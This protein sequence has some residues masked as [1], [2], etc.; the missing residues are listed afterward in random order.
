M[1]KNVWIINRSTG[2]C[3][4]NRAFA[5]SDVDEN[6][7][8]GLISAIFSFAKEIGADSI[9]SLDMGHTQVV[10]LASEYII[11]AL[12][13]FKETSDDFVKIILDKIHDE[14]DRN[15][16]KLM[17]SWNGDLIHFQAFISIVDQIV[18]HQLDR[19]NVELRKI[20]RKTKEI[21]DNLS[22]V[23]SVNELSDLSAQFRVL[24]EE[25]NQIS[26]ANYDKFDEEWV[27]EYF[28]KHLNESRKIR[29][30]VKDI[31]LTTQIR[32]VMVK[33]KLQQQQ[34]KVK[35]ELTVEKNSK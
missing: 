15:Y 24:K 3:L 12:S 26:Y 31:F 6:L 22:K 8:G 30:A 13:V 28:I 20:V 9:K 19:N 29:Q 21:Y 16:G 23:K 32:M 17:E 18:T 4:L 10:Y 14:F 5:P 25:R 11:C 27:N 33:R 2:A 1:I 35:S 7:F 34:K